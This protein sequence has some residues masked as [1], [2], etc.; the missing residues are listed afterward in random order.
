MGG[1][2]GEFKGANPAF[3]GYLNDGRNFALNSVCFNQQGRCI[4]GKGLE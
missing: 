2:S 3:C 4:M 1:K